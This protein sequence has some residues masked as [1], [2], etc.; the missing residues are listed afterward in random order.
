MKNVLS[1]AIPSSPISPI[2]FVSRLVMSGYRTSL[3]YGPSGTGKSL[4]INAVCENI[5]ELCESRDI[6]FGVIQMNCQNVASETVESESYV[7]RIYRRPTASEHSSSSGG[8]VDD[9]AEAD[10]DHRLRVL[11]TLRT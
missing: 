10:S 6:Q 5:V 1:V 2:T 7:G 9:Y 3:L 11:K 8:L 4:I